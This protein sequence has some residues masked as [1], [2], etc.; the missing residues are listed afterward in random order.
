MPPSLRGHS[1][2]STANPSAL[3]ST[4]GSPKRLI[5]SQS[6]PLWLDLNDVLAIHAEQIELRGGPP[7]IRD[8]GLVASAVERPV[9]LYNYDGERDVI[10]LA[11][12]LGIG[13]AENHGFV[14]GNKRAGAFR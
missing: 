5:I 13:I 9:N 11:V 10:T 8:L 4:S 7:G 14:D 1:L 6:D 3:K 2:I 12:R